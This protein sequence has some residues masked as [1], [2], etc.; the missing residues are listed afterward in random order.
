MERIFMDSKG[1]WWTQEKLLAPTNELEAN[2]SFSE[3][4]HFLTT[5]VQMQCGFYSPANPQLFLP[6]LVPGT[7]TLWNCSYTPRSH[8]SLVACKFSS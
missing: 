7:V 3:I 5:W 1:Y 8:F 6:D 4:L 2:I